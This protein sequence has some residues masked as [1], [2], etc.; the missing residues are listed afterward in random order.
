MTQRKILWWSLLLAL[1]GG[2][3]AVVV[4]AAALGG[5]PLREMPLIITSMLVGGFLPPSAAAVMQRIGKTRSQ[6][7]FSP[8]IERT[9]SA[10]RPIVAPEPQALGTVEFISRPGRPLIGMLG[11]VSIIGLPLGGFGATMLVSPSFGASELEAHHKLDFFD[12][13]PLG[14]LMLLAALATISYWVMVVTSQQR[15][16]VSSSGVLVTAQNTTVQFHWGDVQEILV[17]GDHLLF[18]APSL[19][20]S[21]AKRLNRYASFAEGESAFSD[22]WWTPMSPMIVVCKLTALTVGRDL[23]LDEIEHRSGQTVAGR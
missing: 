5:T 23:L 18:K 20:S 13:L 4:V 6:P 8:H 11:I 21:Q 12:V 19:P 10:P 15:V 16:A 7:A 17:Q 1:L 3:T 9:A 14:G 22:P 2:G